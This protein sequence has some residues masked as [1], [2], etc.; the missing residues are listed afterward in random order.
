MSQ[1]WVTGLPEGQG[2]RVED[3][4][5]LKK[6]TGEKTVGSKQIYLMLLLLLELYKEEVHI[7]NMPTVFFVSFEE[8]EVRSTV[9]SLIT[10]ISKYADEDLFSVFRKS[11]W[12]MN[13]SVLSI[14]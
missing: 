11:G 4:V 14:N 12:Y 1:L 7:P 9:Y 8:K 10:I 5:Q 6:K 3:V 2:G 13:A